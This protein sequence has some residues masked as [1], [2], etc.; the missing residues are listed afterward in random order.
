[1]EGYHG[2]AGVS[3]TF[4]NGHRFST[5]DR[6][7]DIWGRNCA[8]KFIGAWWYLACHRSNLNGAYGK[9]TNAQGINWYTYAGYTQSLIETEMKVRRWMPQ[10]EA[11]SVSVIPGD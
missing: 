2:D 7:N 10:S 9:T 3:L 8:S 1:M 4:H 11:L 6:D 5:K